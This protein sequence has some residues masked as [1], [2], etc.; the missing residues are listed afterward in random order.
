[1][2]LLYFF[3]RAHPDA[4]ALTQRAKAIDGF[5]RNGAP[6][7]QW[8]C[9]RPYLL[10]P[11]YD[12][13]NDTSTPV[14]YVKGYKDDDLIGMVASLTYPEEVLDRIVQIMRRDEWFNLQ[15]PYIR[16]HMLFDSYYPKF[17]VTYYHT[18]RYTVVPSTLGGAVHKQWIPNPTTLFR[19]LRERV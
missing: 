8:D 14:P 19:L 16:Q 12:R 7:G 10:A 2:K 15:R 1:M 17:M 18:L 9:E 6:L 13:M 5:F 4:V 3:I 11:L